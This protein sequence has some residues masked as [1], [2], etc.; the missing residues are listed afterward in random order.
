MLIANGL[1]EDEIE[2]KPPVVDDITVKHTVLDSINA[3]LQRIDHTLIN[4]NINQGKTIR[5]AEL[6]KQVKDLEDDNAKAM[7]TI[8]S[9]RKS[10]GE[11]VTL[12]C[13]GNPTVTTSIRVMTNTNSEM[14]AMIGNPVNKTASA[15]ILKEYGTYFVKFLRKYAADAFIVGIRMGLDDTT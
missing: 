10:M 8:A 12:G 2:H 1:S 11:P 15:E 13:S 4:M 14:T 7:L 3:K 5:E 9:L 6:E